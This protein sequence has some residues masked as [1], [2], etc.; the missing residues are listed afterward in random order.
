MRKQ[1][2]RRAGIC[3]SPT[4]SEGWRG[5]RVSVQPRLHFRLTRVS[6]LLKPAVWKEKNMNNAEGLE[7][8][9]AEAE[10]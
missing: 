1:A 4:A 6:F 3:P 2:Q 5:T 8:W 10:W 9:Q 7:A